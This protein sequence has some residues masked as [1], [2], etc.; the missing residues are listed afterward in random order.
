MARALTFQHGDKSIR[1]QTQKIDRAKLY[2]H[3]EVEAKDE[4]GRPCELITMAPDGRTLVAKG[5]RAVAFV[6]PDGNWVDRARLRAIDPDGEPIEAVPSSYDGA[7]ALDTHATIDEY[8]DHQV[9]S[10]YL[11]EPD[12]G[13]EAL[14]ADL[15]GGT[16]YRFPFSFRAGHV[17]DVGF[18]L[19]AQDGKPFLL[20]SQPTTL[21]AIGLDQGGASVA[22]DDEDVDTDQEEMLDFGMM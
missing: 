12:D 4:E 5:G 17:A 3:V 22:Y 19:A 7:I 8:L 11:L 9:K 13:A 20:V 6:S 14:L 2:G 10:V 15:A 18:L 16:I 21:H 1:C